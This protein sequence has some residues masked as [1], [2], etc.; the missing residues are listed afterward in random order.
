MNIIEEI[1]S[2]LIPA[3]G[4]AIGI[5]VEGYPVTRTLDGPDEKH[6][7]VRTLKVVSVSTAH[8]GS[9]AAQDS[10]VIIPIKHTYPVPG[11]WGCFVFDVADVLLQFA[12]EGP[13]A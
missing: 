6:A 11:T 1:R 3:S 13:D 9:F 5:E 10:L 2:K 8:K 7:A 4:K 12:P